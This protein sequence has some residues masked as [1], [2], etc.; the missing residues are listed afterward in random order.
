[1]KI[2]E[3]VSRLRHSQKFFAKIPETEAKAIIAALST[4]HGVRV[5]YA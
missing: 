2:T 3:Q 4:V 1:M 5:G